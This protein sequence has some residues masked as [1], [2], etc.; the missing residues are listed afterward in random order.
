M[1]SEYTINARSAVAAVAASSK[2][3][4]IYFQDTQN[5]IREG[6]YNDGKWTVS[7]KAIFRA[8]RLS[9]L[10]A[11]SWD[12]GSQIRIY[13]ISEDGLLEE[14]CNGS[15]G[16]WVPGYL[17][18]LKVQ[19]AP[20]SSVAAV[21][22]DGT[23]IR[24]YCQESSNAIQEYCVGDPWTRGATLPVADQGSNLAA[25]SWTQKGMV[26]LRIYYQTA[27][28]SVQEHCYDNGWSKGGFNPGIALKNT[29]IAAT[30]WNDSGAQLRIYTQDTYGLLKGYK[31]SGSWEKT[32]FSSSVPVGTHMVAVNWHDGKIVKVY[33][34][35]EDGTIWEEGDD[36]TK[37]Q[38][39]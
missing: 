16:Q 37:K 14:W 31:W 26:H 17:T 20:N 29:A 21:N 6:V 11:V 38:V 35:S 27:D 33:Y 9:P 32:E 30:A 15:G 24:V 10:S 28:L 36:G 4:R 13:S 39:A 7:G 22:W 19:T 3:F 18:K 25:V 23:N 2:S 8:R 1:A 5:G 34:Q 12:G